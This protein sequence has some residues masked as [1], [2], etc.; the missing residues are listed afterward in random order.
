[1]DVGFI[2]DYDP[3]E[4]YRLMSRAGMSF[5]GILASLTTAPSKRFNRSWQTGRITPGMEV[6]IVLLNGASAGHI[7]AFSKVKYTLRGGRII[8]QNTQPSSNPSLTPRAPTPAKSG[9]CG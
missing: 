9:G 1:M 7:T 4:E 6:D 8:F 5:R 2:T 3:T